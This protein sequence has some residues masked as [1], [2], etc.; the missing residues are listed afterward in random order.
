[1]TRPRPRLPDHDAEPVAE[2]DRAVVGHLAAL[3]RRLS[4]LEASFTPTYAPR[5][6]TA[7]TAA[8]SWCLAEARRH[9]PREFVTARKES[10]R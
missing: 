3:E 4:Y 9:H 8:I 6:L 5:W 2:I 10:D 1:M 7:E